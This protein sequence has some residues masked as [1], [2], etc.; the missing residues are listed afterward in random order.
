MSSR[1]SIHI[2]PPTAHS[3]FTELISYLG[4][5]LVSMGET[6]YFTL[7]ASNGDLGWTF[8][9]LLKQMPRD[10]S[11]TRRIQLIAYKLVR[12]LS[13]KVSDPLK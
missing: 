2:P 3:H 7:P 4:Q 12:S 5:Y 8:D 10:V 1:G 6:T 11:G 13:L 9:A